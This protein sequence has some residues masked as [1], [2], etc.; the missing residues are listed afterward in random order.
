MIAYPTIGQRVV[1]HYAQKWLKPHPI[2]T[3]HM[4]GKTGVVVVRGIGT[5]RNHG[6]LVDGTMHVVPCGNLRRVMEK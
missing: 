2:S 6:V 3:A 1:L 5:P 4:H